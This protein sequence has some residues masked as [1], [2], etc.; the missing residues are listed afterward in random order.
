M[1]DTLQE[2]GVKATFFVTLPYAQSEPDLIRRMI[3]EGH[4]IGNHSTTHPSAGL[5]SQDIETQKTKSCRQ[6]PM[7]V[8]NMIIPC[9]CSDSLQGNSANSLWQLS[10]IVIMK[11]FSGV[12]LIWIMMWTISPIRQKVF[13]NDKQTAS[14]RDLSA[15][16]SVCYK[17][18]S[19]W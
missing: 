17:R 6:M 12:L 18:C 5:P 11:V 3:S 13:K 1:L 9:I 2:K 4:V 16:R 7:Y 14:G 10:T 8:S 15:A 19:T